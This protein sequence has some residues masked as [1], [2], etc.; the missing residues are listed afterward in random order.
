MEPSPV[1]EI[2]S[3]ATSRISR[4]LRFTSGDRLSLRS[5]LRFT[6]MADVFESHVRASVEEVGAD[7]LPAW[8]WSEDHL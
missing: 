5:L 4:H 7:E 2:E 6:K 3:E 1:I 8:E